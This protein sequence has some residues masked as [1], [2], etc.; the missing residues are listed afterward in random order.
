MMAFVIPFRSKASSDNWKY[1]S[2]LVN[3]TIKSISNQMNSDFKIIIVY[4]DYPENKVDNEFVIWLHYPFP[5]L[6]VQDITDYESHAKKYLKTD[7]GI[8]FSM[9]K[10]RKSIFGSKHAKELGCNYIMCVDADDLVSNKISEFVADNNRTNC[11]GWYVDKGYVYIENKNLLFHYP[12]KFYN[13]CGSSYIVRS[14]LV[15]IPAFESKNLLD[16]CFFEGHAWLIIFLKDYKRAILQPL[17]FYAAVYILNS[18]SWMN[19]GSIFLKTG[20]KKWAKIF[21]YGQFINGKF[22]REFTLQ[23]IDKKLKCA[24]LRS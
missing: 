14:D 3:R 16:Y 13:F 4:S 22:R 18:V 19:S 24:S 20:L 8:E 2:A 6:K 12:K 21:I 23:K 1:H 5:F 11:P 15:S 10:G 17:P 7:R 9:D